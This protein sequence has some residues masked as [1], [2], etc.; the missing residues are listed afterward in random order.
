MPCIRGV[1]LSEINILSKSS[2]GKNLHTGTSTRY[3]PGVEHEQMFHRA[4]STDFSTKSSNYMVI[5]Q[6]DYFCRLHMG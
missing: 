1:Q 2:S 4:H 6:T 5:C 3:G